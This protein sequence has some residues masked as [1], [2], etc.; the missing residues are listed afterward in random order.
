[1]PTLPS[2]GQG[3]GPAGSRAEPVF[4]RIQDAGNAEGVGQQLD[5]DPASPLFICFSNRLGCLGSLLVSLG[6]TLILLA[7]LGVVEFS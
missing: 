3:G 2:T 1:M 6:L 5:P 7:L 4:R